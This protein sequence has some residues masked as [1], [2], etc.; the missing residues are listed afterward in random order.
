MTIEPT[1]R[2]TLHP[3][4]KRSLRTWI[5][6]TTPIL[7]VLISVRL[8][9]TPIFLHIEYTR[10]SFPPDLYGLST[11]ERLQYGPIALEYLLNT[12]DI[13]YLGD[14]RF[15]DGKEMYNDRE[16][17]HMRD[18][19][20]VTQT[21]FGLAIGIGSIW[22]AAFFLLWR[23]E[24]RTL[25]TALQQGALL[26]QGL[27]AAICLIAIISWDTFFTTFHQ[28]FFADGTWRFEYSDTLIRLFP[29]QFWFDAALSIGGIT[30]VMSLIMQ[31]TARRLRS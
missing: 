7:L 22:I 2:S 25:A 30:I 31:W 23:R 24:K 21:V 10:P 28:M 27:F 29:E 3:I 17:G 15:P 18:V 8:I 9:M 26:T 5:T 16:L 4:T 14:I 13:R 1:S 12:A 6:L 19:K 11:D 20:I